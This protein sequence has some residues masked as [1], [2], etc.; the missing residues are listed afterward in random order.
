MQIDPNL[1]YNFSQQPQTLLTNIG[2]G[3][4]QLGGN[5]VGLIQQK[6][7]AEAEAQRQQQYTDL[8][9]QFNETGDISLIPQMQQ[10]APEKFEEFKQA[11]DMMDEI[12][13]KATVQNSMETLGFLSF[14]NTEKASERLAIASRAYRQAGNEEQAE[15]YQDLSNA[16]LEGR[17]KDVE[18]Y[19]KLAASAS[20]EG[21]AA[22]ESFNAIN[23]DVREE[24]EFALKVMET[25]AG[26]E[27]DQETLNKMDEAARND[28]LYGE[29]ILSA[30]KYAD[31]LE[32]GYELDPQE[33]HKNITEL[34]ERWMKYTSGYQSASGN[35]DKVN[36][37]IDRALSEDDV[38]Q[39]G[40]ADLA[41][42]TAFQRM[43]DDA[44]V[45][46]DDVANIKGANAFV[47]QLGLLIKKVQGGDMLSDP[48][49]Q[50][51]KRL[52]EEYLMA[53]KRYVDEVAYPPLEATYNRLTGGREKDVEGKLYTEVFGQYNAP[54]ELEGT[55]WDVSTSKAPEVPNTVS[56]AIPSSGT[57]RLDQKRA[58]VKQN[59]P[60]SSAN[61]DAMSE[62]QLNRYAA[63]RL[64][65]QD[66]PVIETTEQSVVE[67]NW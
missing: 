22:I 49:R 7:A 64:F 67:V 4:A 60:Q 52:A 34:S 1:I 50:E 44:T 20:P 13:I 26:L 32:G 24:G 39:K 19:L 43:I 47:D 3:A 16:V 12:G 2:Q 25:G 23:K 59:N 14:G 45:R 46:A 31:A 63:G 8:L 40:I 57:A 10:V 11:Y 38:A 6:R 30:L 27:E 65:D 18:S 28:P 35:Y 37:A 9:T 66:N 61:F 29:T 51:M 62:E 33:F 56:N 53:Q 21:Q 36:S 48:Q 55:F 15:L 5:I 54:D 58:F 42:L 41:G 17:T